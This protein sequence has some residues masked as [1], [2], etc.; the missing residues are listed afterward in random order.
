MRAALP[1]AE[2]P[3]A[4]VHKQFE[5]VAPAMRSAKDMHV[6][7]CAHALIAGGYDPQAEVVSLM[8]HNVRDFG[9]RK[10]ADLGIEVTRPDT[11]LLDLFRRDAHGVA[12]AFA[13]LRATLRSAPAPDQLLERLSADGQATTA[14]AM[15][16]AGRHGTVRL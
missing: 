5:A 13:A 4:L 3:V 10:L 1:Q 6:A 16:A 7:A 15:L 12:A 8:T 14:A 2:L 9:V 11:F